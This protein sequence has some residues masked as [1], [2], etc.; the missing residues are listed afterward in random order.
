MVEAINADRAARIYGITPRKLQK[1]RAWPTV[2]VVD[3]FPAQLTF[4]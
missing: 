4:P 1:L 3:R 2:F